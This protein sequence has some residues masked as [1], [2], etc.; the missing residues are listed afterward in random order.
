MTDTLATY[1]TIIHDDYQSKFKIFH[2]IIDLQMQMA[3]QSYMVYHRAEAWS[4]G[5]PVD[6]VCCDDHPC[7]NN[8]SSN[9]GNADCFHLGCQDNDPATK[10]LA[11]HEDKTPCPDR[12]TPY[13][14]SLDWFLD[15]PDK[16]Y[17]KLSDEYGVP[18]DWVEF[19]DLDVNYVYGCAWGQV[20][21]T[22]TDLAKCQ[23]KQDSFWNNYPQ[24]KKGYK[25][26][27]P[28]DVIKGGYGNAKDLI[29]ESRDQM[30][31]AELGLESWGEIAHTLL[32]PTLTMSS[33]VEK[34]QGIVKIADEKIE[35]ERK[36]A[37]ADW[38]TAILFFIPL[39]GEAAEAVGAVVLRT[40]LN[41]AGDLADVGYSVYSTVS[42]KDN[43]L[44]NI[45]GM[46]PGIKSAKSSFKEVALEVR[47]LQPG[48]VNKLPKAMKDEVVKVRKLQ[49]FCKRK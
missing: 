43:I 10:C 7:R 34:M 18:K 35:A 20:D 14:P 11:K 26:S 23:T 17:K 16:F 45:L 32:L 37:I 1:D 28:S 8:G 29:A 24:L 39:A 25:L 6:K 22:G 15:D 48:Q 40:L 49:G 38:I 47:N 9:I 2:G 36:A 30:E 12:V 42:D 46:I 3:I 4:C 13:P 41:L 5:T 27:D 21:E 31:L 33:A 44:T 19:V